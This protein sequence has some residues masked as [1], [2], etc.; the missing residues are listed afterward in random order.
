RHLAAQSPRPLEHHA[1]R[2]PRARRRPTRPP[3]T[4]RRLPRARRQ[5]HLLRLHAHPQRNHRRRRRL[6]RRPRGLRA[7]PPLS[8]LISQPSTH[9]GPPRT[10][11][12]R[13]VHRRLAQTLIRIQKA[14]A[15][16][17]RELARAPR[18]APHIPRHSV[19]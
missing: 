15:P 4:R 1:R 11:R 2:R 9:P 5:T 14:T 17:G 8:T 18:S 13:H 16:V 6:H 7:P 12:Q 10:Q 3:R 19:I